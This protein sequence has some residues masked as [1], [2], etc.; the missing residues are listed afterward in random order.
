MET[1][2]WIIQVGLMYQQVFLQE[3]EGGRR[4]SQRRSCHDKW[5]EGMGIREARVRGHVSLQKLEKA[6]KRI[7]P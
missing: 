2:V 4:Q 6:R 7:L 1:L 3:E 5:F